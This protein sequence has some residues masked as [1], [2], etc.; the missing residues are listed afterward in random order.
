MLILVCSL[1]AWCIVSGDHTQWHWHGY[2]STTIRTMNHSHFHE[3]TRPYS[4]AMM[5]KISL[6]SSVRSE[7]DLKHGSSLF[8]SE[9]ALESIFAGQNPED[10]SKAKFII[11]GGWPYGFG[12]RIHM[13]GVVLA[14]AIE[15][16][17]VYLPH[18]DGDNIMWET[19][20]PFCS[21]N[22]TSREVTMQCFYLPASKCT[23][24]D[25]LKS[26][27]MDDVN[28]LQTFKFRDFESGIPSALPDT[29]NL[30][31][32]A[33][34]NGKEL[35]MLKFV[36][37][38]FKSMLQSSSPLRSDAYYYWWRAISATYLLR[39]NQATLTEL[40]RLASKEP[41]ANAVVG[42]GRSCVAMFVRHGDK[43]SE[44]KLLD[45]SVYRDTAVKM[46]TEGLVPGSKHLKASADSGGVNASMF[47]TTEDPGVLEAAAQWSSSSKWRVAFTTLF[48]RSQQ[49]AVKSYEELV[50][51][52]NANKL[53]HDLE[54]LS[55]LLNL[56][57][58]LRCE[59]WV[60]TLASNSCRII[61]ELRCTIGA[62][63]NRHYADLS[64]ET[65]S[66]PPCFAGY[67]HI[68]NFGT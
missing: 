59:A 67:G 21:Q 50:K 68:V 13:E 11:S 33:V 24:K 5:S 62:K 12:A 27:K 41:A 17:R 15:T 28:K 48:D 42:E 14:L 56:Q 36:P 22:R 20:V 54:Y 40:E 18:P 39:P 34:A 2:N 64:E 55:M 19:N 8:G 66:S 35:T 65:C 32:E 45:F 4:D 46:W 10:C 43:G 44:M 9:L 49:V 29:F 26:G 23:I 47:I 16:G 7:F 30:L 61:D 53:H 25:A 60:C 37:S 57:Y 51:V 63:C 1:L 31:I 58:A 38:Q 6:W 3:F 52:K